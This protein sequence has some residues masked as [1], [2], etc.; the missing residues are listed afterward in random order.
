MQQKEKTWVDPRPKRGDVY[1]GRIERGKPWPEFPDGFRI[2]VT[3]GSMNKIDGH[4][5]TQ[6]SPMYLS[7]PSHTN[8]SIFENWWQY[9]KRYKELGHFDYATGAPTPAWY[10]F[11]EKGWALRKGQRHAR[12]TKTKLVKRTAMVKG[13]IRRSYHYLKPACS[14]FEGKDYS[15][16]QARKQWYVPMY[17]FEVRQTAFYSALQFQVDQGHKVL[18][19]DYDGP[20][21]AVMVQITL[22]ELIHRVNEESQPFGHAYVLGGLLA[23][24]STEFYCRYGE[25]KM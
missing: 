4:P 9:A 22:G 10:K 16:I 5:A 18:L 24:L 13:K 23:G 2:N 21:D 14:H 17:S 7:G 8:W 11:N 1:V 20:Q 19:L 25:G 15:Y 3:S 6:V 12:G